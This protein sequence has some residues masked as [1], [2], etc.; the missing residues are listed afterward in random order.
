[1]PGMNAAASTPVAALHLND[2]HA[3]L[4]ATPIAR[5]LRPADRTQAQSL[6]RLAT[7]RREPLVAM[8]ARH[9]MGGQQF[10]RHGSVLDTQRLSRVLSFDVHRGRITVEAGIR[11]PALLDWLARSP[12]NAVGWTIRQKQTGADDFSLGGAVAANI[13]GRGLAFAPF[14]D[15]IES[16]EVLDARGELR[17]AS[18]SENA[19][20]FAL[21]VGG[22]G[23]FGVVLSLTLRLVPRVTVRRDVHLARAADVIA[24]LETARDRGATYGDF[25]FAIDP[26]SPDFLDLGIV[27]CYTPIPGTL[28][29]AA[30]RHLGHDGFAALLA[31]AHHAPSEAF[32]RYADFY[33]SSDGQLYAS[34]AQ[35][36]GV[37]LGDYHHAIDRSLGHC[38]SEMIS[39]L[40]VPRERLPRFLAD[41]AEALRRHRAQPIYGTV[42]LIERDVDTQLAW[43]REPWACI[44]FNLHVRHD[45]AGLADARDAFR[46]LIDAALS[47][48]GSFYLTYHRWATR[49][50]LDAAYPQLSGWIDAKYAHDP[51]AL[52]RSDWWLALA[53]M[54]GRAPRD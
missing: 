31:L 9:A 42:R 19:D 23:M 40:Y 1:M 30:P 3:H 17:K 46:A 7:A 33:L 6:V 39:E 8:G 36:M 10:L 4:N 20:L 26:A 53:A 27:S 48:G 37:Y 2:V 14:V 28:P 47:L 35:Q 32:A 29:D 43:A 52:F 44:V 51:H 15:D 49:R 25:Q 16:L 41:A 5:V 54:H 13:H 24:R 34:D 50:Q 11:W 21:V 22:Y 38:G 12:A 18:R 45:D